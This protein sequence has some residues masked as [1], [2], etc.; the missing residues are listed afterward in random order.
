MVVANS[1]NFIFR[2]V[3]TTKNCC[4][5]V[6]IYNRFVNLQQNRRFTTTMNTD[7]GDPGG[8]IDTS[9]RRRP[10]IAT[11]ARFRARVIA[12]RLAVT[13][14]ARQQEGLSKWLVP[15]QICLKGHDRKHSTFIIHHGKASGWDPI[16]RPSTAPL[17]VGISL[18]W[19][20]EEDLF[21]SL[22]PSLLPSKRPLSAANQT[23]PLDAANERKKRRNEPQMSRA[24]ECV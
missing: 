13:G 9:R 19:A 2:H 23:S 8:L 17:S 22:S 21:F 6:L 11:A 15:Y 5:L 14:V 16:R 1:T 18:P 24:A 12:Q 7:P 3:L 20:N 4:R 10:P